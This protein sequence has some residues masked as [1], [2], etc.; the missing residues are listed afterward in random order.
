M[1]IGQEGKL[2]YLRMNL[3]LKGAQIYV[4][5]GRLERFKTGAA[6]ALQE[7]IVSPRVWTGKLV[8]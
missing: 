1:M 6:T 4:Y 3:Q 8:L 2:I 7:G 5:E